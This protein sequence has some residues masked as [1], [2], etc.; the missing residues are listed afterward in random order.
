MTKRPSPNR[1]N[2]IRITIIDDHHIVVDGLKSLFVNEKGYQVLAEGYTAADAI[3]LARLQDFDVMLMDINMP[4]TSG[5]DAAREILTFKPRARIIALTM[6]DSP[7]MI[8]ECVDAGM[9]GYILKNTVKDELLK[10]VREV[11]A[12]REFI[13]SATE[14]ALKANIGNEQDKDQPLIEKLL[15]KREKEILSHI[16]EE[17]TTPQIA[18]ILCLSTLTVETHRKN[19]LHKLGLK[20]TA[21]LVKMAVESGFR[22]IP[23]AQKI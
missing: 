14:S 15:T 2:V 17:C 1:A 6:N 22:Y 20:N 9:V 21:G 13:S 4:D 16:L 18:E 8:R 19:I 10:A 23:P 7:Q 11:Y 12:G 3:S 5:L